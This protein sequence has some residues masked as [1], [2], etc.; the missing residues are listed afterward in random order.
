MRRI[1][2]KVLSMMCS[3]GVV[4][5]A[6]SLPAFSADWVHI[7][8]MGD[9]NND[10]E[11]NMADLVIMSRH[12]HGNEPLTN[13]NSYH[14]YNSYIG[15]NGADGF[16]A[17]E[18]FVTADVDQNGEVD[19]F[20][21]IQLRKAIVSGQWLYVWQWE[22]KNFAED[23]LIDTGDFI[24]PGVNDVFKYM[25]SQGNGR[26]LI[27]YTD[28]KDC[29]YSYLPSEEEIENIAFGSENSSNRQYPF[30]SISAFYKRSSKGI[31]N[32][33]GKA[34]H[35]TAKHSLGHYQLVPGQKEL[36]AEAIASLDGNIDYNDFDGNKDGYIDT[37]L[38]VVPTEAGEETWWPAAVQYNQDELSYDG[39]KIGDM[40]TG[41]CQIVSRSDY[42]DFT[43]TILHELG[44]C[45]G[46]PDYY[47]Y[48]VESDFDGLHG[49]AGSELMDDSGGDFSCV[50]KIQLGWYKEDQV[51]VY[52]PES[53]T[54]TYTLY[55]AQ[56]GKG[57]TV[58]IPCGTDEKGHHGEYMMIEY[59][60]KDANNSSPPWYVAMGEGIRVYHSEMSLYNN[61]WW[62]TYKYASGSEF[63]YSNAGKRFIRII[64]D[65]DTDNIYKSGAVIDGNIGGFHWYDKNGRETVDTG[66]VIEVGEKNNDSYTITIRSK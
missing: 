24:Y 52:S 6:F 39:V 40:I 7:G 65:R 53:G 56:S 30:E 66:L 61:G 42:K 11:L 45:M 43:S 58:I 17:G 50:S 57:N 13:K 20:D 41:N 60:T 32:L 31:M 59:T 2:G 49:T 27:I 19:I 62:T 29:K 33:S 5:S 54:Q 51:S 34:Y 9:L 21:M 14:V 26:L 25:P 23:P 48:D 35:Y 44:H 64:D 18:Y 10:S 12:L 36:V 46:L 28:F 15:I 63:T 37:V 4:L 22:T 47:L 38:L 8:Y 55:N 3:V 16:E 1:I